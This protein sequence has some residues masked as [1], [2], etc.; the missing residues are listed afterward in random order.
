MEIQKGKLLY[1][2]RTKKIYPIPDNPDHLII[3]FKDDVLASQDGK[4]VRIKNGGTNSAAISMTLF[5]YLEGY[6]V[7]THF[8]RVLKPNE[9][10]VR[11][12][13]ILPVNIIVWN[14]TEANLSK[15]FG[16]KRGME[17]PY[18]ITEYYFVDEKLHRQMITP[19]HICAFGYATPEEMQI[20]DKTIRKINTVLKSFFE[21]RGLM[22]ARLNLEFGRYK[23]RIWVGDA[24]CPDAY[25]L[26]EAES[27]GTQLKDAFQWDADDADVAYEALKN[28]ICK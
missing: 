17:L 9:M 22:L 10:L 26:W 2:G 16:V 20:I 24:L 23:D 3:Q 11:K 6:H 13:D 5:K 15:R 8:I 7:R 19:D 12:L 4:N 14:F 28:R 18:S 25:L 27:G 1:E 21:R